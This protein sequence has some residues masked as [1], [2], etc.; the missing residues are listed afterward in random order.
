M[1]ML[2]RRTA[3]ALLASALAP[4]IALAYR[5]HLSLT[6][7]SLN[8]KSNH[9]EIEHE[10]HY[11]DAEFALRRQPGASRLPLASTEGRAHMALY[12]EERFALRAPDGRAHVLRT[13]G[14]DV[15]SN[16]LLVFQEYYPLSPG[17][18]RMRNTIL[19]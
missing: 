10:P 15:A 6:K 2:N 11:H 4:S 17:R 9:W 3:L 8:S 12:V 13:V 7:I 14:A 1:S 16:T 19:Q 5:A 18:Y